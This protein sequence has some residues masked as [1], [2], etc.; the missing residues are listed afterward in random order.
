MLENL[1]LRELQIVQRHLEKVNPPPIL[2]RYRRANEWALKEISN[3]EVHVASPAD[4]N[5]PFEYQ[6]TLS[7]KLEDL[8]EAMYG[9]CLA[10]GKCETEAQ[11]EAIRVV[12]TY[13]FSVVVRRGCKLLRRR[14]SQNT[15]IPARAAPPA[16]LGNRTL[17]CGG[18]RL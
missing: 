9:F 10:Q 6:A 11:E 8:K 12:C 5:D 7:V 3:S 16:S 15:D 4:M 13:L 1:S 18:G 2:Y 14:Q 17:R